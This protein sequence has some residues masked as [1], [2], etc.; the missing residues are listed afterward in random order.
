[1]IVASSLLLLQIA[2]AAAIAS[3]NSPVQTM[4]AEQEIQT[5]S[6]RDTKDP[7]FKSY[8]RMLSGLDAFEQHHRM[9][10]ASLPQSIPK[11]K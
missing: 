1:M 7:E 4:D 9:A 5:I 10:P 11:V 8:R 3:E 2:S 6:I